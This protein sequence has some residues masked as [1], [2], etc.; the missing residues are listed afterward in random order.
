MFLSLY[1]MLAWQI[2]ALDWSESR[3]LGWQSAALD[4]SDKEMFCSVKLSVCMCQVECMYVSVSCNV[5]L[6]LDLSVTDC[7][8][9]MSRSMYLY[10]LYQERCVWCI[11]FIITTTTTSSSS[12]YIHRNTNASSLFKHNNNKLILCPSNNNLDVTKTTT[13][14]LCFFQ[15]IFVSC[16][17]FCFHV[18]I[19]KSMFKML[20]FIMFYV[21]KNV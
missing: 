18:L 21:I 15:I 9:C 16:N 20:F 12:L 7:W 5:N 13:D 19:L 2:A 3:M 17:N 1:R 14:L 4:W 10:A 6:K 8:H 11:L